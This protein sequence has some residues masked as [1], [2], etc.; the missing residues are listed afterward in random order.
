[1][2]E[3]MVEMIL[4]CSSNDSQSYFIWLFLH[5]GTIK[6]R[7]QVHGMNPGKV[8]GPIYHFLL[9]DVSE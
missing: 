4:C 6:I 9:V 1:M 2:R 7:E 8:Y 5:P 3:C